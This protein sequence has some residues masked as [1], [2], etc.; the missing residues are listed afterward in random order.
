[1]ADALRASRERD[2]ALVGRGV[3]GVADADARAALRAQ[4]AD[5]GAA[6]ADDRTA[7]D[8]GNGDLLSRKHSGSAGT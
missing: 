5:H 2:D 1:M 4:V 6:L 8:R 7:A 3:V